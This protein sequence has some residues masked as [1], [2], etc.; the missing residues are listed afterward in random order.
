MNHVVLRAVGAA[1]IN[2]LAIALVNEITKAVMNPYERHVP[3][4]PEYCRHANLMHRVGK[5]P[6]VNHAYLQHDAEFPAGDGPK[7]VIRLR[8]DANGS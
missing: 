1:S 3:G 7:E 8:I 6:L 2:S 4:H 5:M